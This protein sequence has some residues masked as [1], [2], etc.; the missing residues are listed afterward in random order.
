MNRPGASLSPSNPYAKA[1]NVQ[2][3]EIRIIGVVKAG[4]STQIVEVVVPQI[5][6]ETTIVKLMRKLGPQATVFAYHG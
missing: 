5:E 1:N 2:K 6:R 4:M 3:N